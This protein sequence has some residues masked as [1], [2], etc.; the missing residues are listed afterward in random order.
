VRAAGGNVRGPR[1]DL[2]VERPGSRAPGWRVTGIYLIAILPLILVVAAT[3]DVEVTG[4]VRGTE[5]FYAAAA[6]IAAALAIA[7]T[8]AVSQLRDELE[9]IQRELPSPLSHP[10]LFRDLSLGSAMA[11]VIFALMQSLIALNNCHG[12]AHGN[13]FCGIHSNY[14]FTTAGITGAAAVLVIP[15]ALFFWPAAGDRVASS[16]DA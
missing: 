12:D 9:R 1:D 4:K 13:R 2:R 3:I 5:G 16:S 14:V 6:T 10:R 15:V 8:L 7:L 11:F